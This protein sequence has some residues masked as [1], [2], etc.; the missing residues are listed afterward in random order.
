[1]HLEPRTDQPLQQGD[2]IQDVPFV[3]ISGVFNVKVNNVQGQSRVDC[4]DASTLDKVKQFSQGNAM[5]VSSLPLVIQPG[6]V[7]TQGCDIDH[8]DFITLARIFPLELLIQ[9]VKEAVNHDEPLILYDLIRRL[10]EGHDYPH[11][12]YLG[13]LDGKNRYA[14]DL[15]RVQS[16]PPSRGKSAS[17]RSGG[18]R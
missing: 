11:L 3:V 14:A 5:T 12:L 16:F 15:L 7:V 2:I 13:A 17:V 6:I 18:K 10:T 9:E 8:R 1:M 4:G